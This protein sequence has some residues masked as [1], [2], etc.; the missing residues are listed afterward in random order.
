M[1]ALQDHL[2][3]ALEELYRTFEAATPLMIEGCP[4]CVDGREIDVLLSKP[5]RQISCQEL[6]HYIGGVFHTVG[7]ELDFRYFLPRILEISIAADNNTPR[8]EIVIGKLRLAGWQNWP[9]HERQ[10]V[11][12]CLDLWFEQALTWDKAEAD[13]DYGLSSYRTEAILCG[14]ALADLPLDRWLARLKQPD[15]RFVMQDL[16]EQFPN[17]PNGF[18]RNALGGFVEVSKGLA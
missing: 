7:D 2:V 14:A 11:I 17:K 1:D 10:A 12:N 5:L 16:R 8:A 4:C 13:E 15:V 9:F 3:A 18:W 6:M